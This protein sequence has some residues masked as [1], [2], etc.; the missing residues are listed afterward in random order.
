MAE[1]KDPENTI[2]LETTKGKV[3]IQLLPRW[4]LSTSPASRNWPAKGL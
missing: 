4:R 2:I 3:V 1:I